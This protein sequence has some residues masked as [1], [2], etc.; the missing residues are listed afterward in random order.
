MCLFTVITKA[1]KKTV[2]H[3]REKIKINKNVILQ[4]VR[5]YTQK[6][7]PH[8]SKNAE[9]NDFYSCPHVG[10]WTTLKTTLCQILSWWRGG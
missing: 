4:P 2:I 3:G 8:Q 1:I 7:C 10:F 5:Q 9:I 6:I